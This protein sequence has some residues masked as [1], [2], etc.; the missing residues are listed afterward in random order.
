MKSSLCK[1]TKHTHMAQC[2]NGSAVVSAGAHCGRQCTASALLP[3]TTNTTTLPKM[4][5]K[6]IGIVLLSV[7]D[8]VDA[9]SPTFC[10]RISFFS[11]FVAV[12]ALGVCTNLNANARK[13]TGASRLMLPVVARFHWTR[14]SG[15]G[16][17]PPCHMNTALA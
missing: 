3:H 8:A 7:H 17:M 4:E 11:S 1:D 6:S 13:S 5:S 15:C 16:W 10:C 2:V 12:D 14:I 9:S